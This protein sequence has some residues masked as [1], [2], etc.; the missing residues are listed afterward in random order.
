MKTAPR[1]ARPFAEWLH[2]QRNGHAAVEL[3]EASAT[4]SASW[5]TR[6]PSRPRPASGARSPS[7]SSFV[8]GVAPFEGSAGYKIRARLRYRLAEGTLFIG[9]VLDR[10][11]KVVRAAFDDVLAEVEQTTGLKSFA[12]TP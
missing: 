7:R 1:H 2:E 5:S 8:V 12:G 3:S 6:R 10:P 9:Y 4:A 11:D